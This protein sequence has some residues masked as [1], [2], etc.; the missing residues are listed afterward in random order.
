[1]DEFQEDFTPLGVILNIGFSTGKVK[2][3][4]TELNF[5]CHGDGNTALFH[6]QPMQHSLD[7]SPLMGYIMIG[8]MEPLRG[9]YRLK[10]DQL[11]DSCIFVYDSPTA[12]V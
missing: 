5:L 2:N 4:F 10:K 7:Y 12:T 9:R 1:V 11:T 8:L 6:Q 3:F